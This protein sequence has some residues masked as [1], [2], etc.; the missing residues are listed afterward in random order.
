DERISAQTG[1]DS[2]KPVANSGAQDTIPP[3][4]KG[5]SSSARKRSSRAQQGD[6]R[7]QATPRRKPRNSSVPAAERTDKG[8]I[9][10]LPIRQNAHGASPQ[11]PEESPQNE[12]MLGELEA[13]GFT[14]DEAYHLIHV[15]DRIANSRE[16]R[17]AEAVIRRLRF[18]RWLF[19]QG[20]LSEF[21]A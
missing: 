16:M 2:S 8:E 14:Q 7:T 10:E 12:A 17:E 1:N 15:S 13:Q 18:N 20:K 6:S 4:L 19:E 9:I 3:E 21:S 11:Q 5:T